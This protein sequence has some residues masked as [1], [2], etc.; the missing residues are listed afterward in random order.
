ML[1]VDIPADGNFHSVVFGFDVQ[2]DLL[3]TI[4]DG[5]TCAKSLHA[6]KLR[7]ASFIEGAVL[8]EDIDER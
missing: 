8:I 6:C 5:S 2:T 1:S 7:S 4:Y 3:E